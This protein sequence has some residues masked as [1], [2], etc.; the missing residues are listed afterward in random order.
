M[1]FYNRKEE[2]EILRRNREMSKKFGV[3]TVITGRR[4]IGKTAL[5]RE[6]GKDGRSLYLFVPRSTESLLCEQLVKNADTDL[7][8]EIF[9]TGRFRD[10]FEQLLIYGGKN[11]FTFVIDEFQDLKRMN[12]SIMSSIQELWDK[13]KQISKVNLIVCGSVYSMMV[14]IFEDQKEPLFG[15]AVSKMNMAPFRPSA[16]KEILKDHNPVFVP[17]DLLFLYMVSGG[18]PKYIELLM[19]AG[20]VTFDGMLDSVCSMDSLFITDGRELLISEFGADHGTYFS[21]LQL[22]AGGR[23]T[24]KEISEA[25]GKEAGA[26][27]ENLEKR[28]GVVRK[29]RP[30]F[31]KKNS[32]DVRWRVSDNYLRFYFR[33]I[34]SNLS[35]IELRRYDILKERISSEYA[36]YS[37]S[38]LEDYFREKIAEEERVTEIGSYWDKKGQNEIDIIALDGIGSKAAVAEVKRDRRKAD[39]KVLEEKAERVPGLK[40][41]EITYRTLSPEDM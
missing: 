11:N 21:I 27:L 9:N 16:V 2:L 31:S 23:N 35:L 3:F 15:R 30:V 22:I 28:Y 41:Y 10:I 4:R 36:Q 20:A 37:G 5:I 13:Y 8:I 7:G 24:L 17:D 33:F 38:V 40:G 34:N 25:I 1:K 12:P 29:N 39:L 26:Y 18:V 14:E 32:R 19:D 6:F